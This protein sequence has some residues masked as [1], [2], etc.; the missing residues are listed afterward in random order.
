LRRTRRL[1]PQEQRQFSNFDERREAWRGEAHDRG[2]RRTMSIP[3]DVV[4]AA[5][6]LYVSL[7]S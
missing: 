2:V 5:V 7:F 4:V 1:R 3:A 6:I